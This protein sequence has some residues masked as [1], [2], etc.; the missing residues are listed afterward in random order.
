[1]KGK[2]STFLSFPTRKGLILTKRRACNINAM[3]NCGFL[4]WSVDFEEIP[5]LQV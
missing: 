2:A 1:M 4:V 5:S 3:Y